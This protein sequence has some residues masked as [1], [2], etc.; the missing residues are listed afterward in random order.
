MGERAAT[1]PAE[2]RGSA[3]PN[4]ARGHAPARTRRQSRRPARGSPPRRCGHSPPPPPSARC[5]R[6]SAGRPGRSAV[7]P[8]AAAPG[9][10]SSDNPRLSVRRD[11]IPRRARRP[12]ARARSA[13]ASIRPS[14]N[15]GRRASCSASA[16]AWLRMA[17]T[18]A[19]QRRTRLQQPEEINA[20]GQPL[21]DI[22]EAVHRPHRIGRPAEG[23]DQDRQHRLERLLRRGAAQR[24]RLAAA[25]ALDPL[26]RRDRIG[27]AGAASSAASAS[28]LRGSL[29]SSSPV[30]RIVERADTSRAADRADAS[31]SRRQT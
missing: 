28:A 25:P 18:S 8:L 12:K 7:R 22:V 6:R 23:L 9:R 15:S 20:G 31:S 14:S 29:V 24:A 13:R 21:D 17:A 4:L 19:G 3:A 30:E 26:P 10:G 2:R 27:E 1:E 5:A 16:G 11:G